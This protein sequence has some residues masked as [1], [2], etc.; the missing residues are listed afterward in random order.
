MT[1]IRIRKRKGILSF[2]SWFWFSCFYY[3]VMNIDLVIVI[4]DC[5]IG[6]SS[7]MLLCYLTLHM[8]YFFFL[9]VVLHF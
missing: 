6:V 3:F 5:F 1:V 8:L 9:H 4:E 2:D 7:H